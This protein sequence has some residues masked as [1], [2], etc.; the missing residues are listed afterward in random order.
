MGLEVKSLKILSGIWIKLT[1]YIS[2]DIV[3]AWF[4]QNFKLLLALE[5]IS[6]LAAGTFLYF[7]P[8]IYE[9]NFAVRLPKMEVSSSSDV[10]KE[11]SK[12]QSPKN[13]WVLLIS[14]LDFLRGLQNPMGHSY[15]L[16]QTCMGEETNANRRK[17]IQG[18]QIS[19]M[20]GGDI[21]YF[22]LRQE[23]RERASQCATLFKTLVF[24]DLNGIY[25]SQAQKNAP[26]VIRLEKAVITE[27]IHLSDSYI[28]PN[29]QKTI[30]AAL[31]AG[32]LLAIFGVSL[33]N[34]YRA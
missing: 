7:T 28:Y 1:M 13:Q 12:A 5:C 20:G 14:G 29:L 32:F 23:G 11:G 18:L 22:S 3:S 10:S 24:E 25:N 2:Y 26:N 31:I 8:H 21:I 15:E 4:R 34:K 16:I 17:F 6:L 9:A 33:R 30:L 27:D 19:L